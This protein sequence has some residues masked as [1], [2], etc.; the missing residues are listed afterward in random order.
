[1]TN[2]RLFGHDI[3]LMFLYL[4]L[5]EFLLLV[6]SVFSAAYTRNYFM[7]DVEGWPELSDLERITGP[8]LPNAAVYA[9]LMLLAITAMG[10]Y[11]GGYLRLGKRGVIARIVVAHLSGILLFTFLVYA[12][13]GLFLGRGLLFLAVMY[14][15][16][17]IILSR[18]AFGNFVESRALE[19]RVLVYGAGA[20]AK[21]IED[22]ESQL[23]RHGTRLCGCV[24]V[25]KEPVEVSSTHVIDNFE[26]LPD[27]VD[28][29]DID[30]IVVAADDRR[31]SL[32]VDELLECRLNGVTVS[33]LANFIERESGK[34]RLD[35]MS[36]S[37]LIFS[38]GFAQGMFRDVVERV[39]DVAGSLLL[40]AVASPVMLLTAV[41][42][43]IEDGLRAPVIYRQTRI[44]KDGKPFS[45]LK[46][47]SMREDAEKLGA[48]WA[49][50]DDDRVT[51]VGSVI[52]KLRIDELP[53]TINV[54]RG[55]MSFVGPRPERPEF[56]RELARKLPYYSERHRVKP[57][58]TGWA[59]LNYP[60][61]ASD[62]DALEKLQYDM[63]YAK[64]HT[65]ILDLFIL[66][67]TV[68]V[69][70]FGKGAR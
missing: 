67:Q 28:R 22:M 66:I 6:A 11:S 62:R 40:L 37:T 8:L 30:E 36:P 47:R 50:D 16:A 1:M 24:R 70:L 65:L 15:M 48:Q 54:L 25:N 64:H 29:F 7:G 4:A 63:Y 51:R 41:A 45:V 56:V 53:Q 34:L 43:K 61:G 57:G 5:V 68:E 39:F 33:D 13:P 17:F 31:N 58:I 26:P 60:Y 3:P 32:L 59:Q 55:D 38:E 14:S 21:L 18:K 9:L 27:L 23:N 49:R 35:I 42:I 12:F 10:L 69:V 2:I 44:G 52:R 46:F 20:R 19:R